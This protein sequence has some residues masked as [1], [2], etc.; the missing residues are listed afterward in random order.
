MTI[1]TLARVCSAVMVDVRVVVRLDDLLLLFVILVMGYE[2][3]GYTSW[4]VLVQKPL[5]LSKT[6]CSF[7]LLY[8]GL[9]FGW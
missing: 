5:L 1:K 2:R 3:D 7:M 8:L 9:V 6:C 4:R